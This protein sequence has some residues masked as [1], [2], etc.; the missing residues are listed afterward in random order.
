MLF[1]PIA[2]MFC[3]ILTLA[4]CAGCGGSGGGAGPTTTPSARVVIE[5]PST[6]AVTTAAS[7]T[8][9]GVNLG[10]V[11]VAAVEIGGLSAASTDGYARWSFAAQLAPGIELLD[12]GYRLEPGGA[13]LSAGALELH[14]VGS[15]MQ[16]PVCHAVGPDG[17]VLVFEEE[18]SVLIQIDP[19][20]TTNRLVAGHGRGAGGSLAG[21]QDIVF[22]PSGSR[23]FVLSTGNYIFDVDLATG[24]RDPVFDNRP[25]P[26]IVFS[27]GATMA[28]DE[29]G[30]RLLVADPV[31][32]ALIE[33]ELDG[34]TRGR[35]EYFSGRGAGS[36]VAFV[37]PQSV[38]VD[39]VGRRALV[40]DHEAG[41]VVAVDLS[42]GAR[43]TMR[44]GLALP[45]SIA[46]DVPT[47]R[48]FVVDA[49]PADLLEITALGTREVSSGVR[50]VGSGPLLHS[51]ERIEMDASTGHVLVLDT[52][53]AALVG[54]DP[55]SGDRIARY[56]VSAGRGP[57]FR[58]PSGIV[59]DLVGRRALVVDRTAAAVF[60]VDMATGERVL[61]SSARESIGSGDSLEAPVAIAL[62]RARG[63][64]LVTDLDG[65]TAIDLVS[66]D[67]RQ[68][69]TGLSGTVP[70]SNFVAIDVDA[71][72]DVIL[73]AN[74]SE[75]WMLDPGTGQ[76]QPFSSASRGAGP[77][78][79]A[80]Y[81][82]VA[83]PE[84][85]RVLALVETASGPS[86]LA[87]DL[88]TGN[89]DVVALLNRQPVPGLTF[90][91]VSRR[92]WV[93]TISGVTSI[94]TDNGA[95]RVVR[96]RIGTGVLLPYA[97]AVCLGLTDDVLLACDAQLAGVQAVDVST[98]DRVLMSR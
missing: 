34:P 81:G 45:R 49:G 76:G 29:A 41:S 46:I 43:T 93:V 16:A 84:R 86:L 89:R 11:P 12:V 32:R 61:L 58:G 88:A 56:R 68:L 60:A 70:P 87:A 37:R 64:A 4:A 42:N 63:R 48:V 78:F 35:S 74:D 39:P 27:S 31:Q 65:V 69:S 85:A 59:R 75:L 80:V 90:D 91:P 36:G 67:R 17:S 20:G 7:I 26:Q 30:R 54:V 24:D 8:V 71:V 95:T 15:L 22:D 62:D 57:A 2:R 3:V 40:V 98:A 51:A 14:Q 33:V 96:P 6:N 47:Q 18:N 52:T 1:E 97:T 79:S 50:R 19:S 44:A 55:G 25:G 5:F 82:M 9:R 10:P 94:D 53:A 28:F 38:V 21:V 23:A 77:V 72:R 13:P 92:A 83:D 73:V 66:G